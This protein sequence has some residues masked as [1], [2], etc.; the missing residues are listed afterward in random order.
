VP[1]GGVETPM[2]LPPTDFE[3]LKNGFS[4]CDANA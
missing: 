2:E 1:E 4:Y 3:S